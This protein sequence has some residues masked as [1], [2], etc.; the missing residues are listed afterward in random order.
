MMLTNIHDRRVAI[1]GGL[2]VPEDEL[3][4]YDLV[5]RTNNHWLRTGGRIHGLFHAGCM[6]PDP[7]AVLSEVARNEDFEL[8][9]LPSWSSACGR[10]VDYMSDDMSY[11]KCIY[12]DDSGMS[13]K[14]FWY[15]NLCRKLRTF[16]DCGVP[17]TGFSAAAWAL[18]RPIG[19]LYM[20][21]MNLYG[22]R[23]DRRE[24]HNLYGHAKLLMEWMKVDTRVRACPELIQSA[25]LI[26]EEEEHGK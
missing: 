23:E 21:G 25:K 10:V 24:P 9:A 12:F 1:V 3:A 14:H 11:W 6:N 22:N 18:V 15:A 19:R 2:D 8:V 7:I 20:T 16:K 4:E 26:I 5:I 13:P 17:L